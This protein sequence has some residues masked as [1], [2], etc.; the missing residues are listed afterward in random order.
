MYFDQ[1]GYLGAVLLYVAL[2][3]E[4]YKM[5][6]TLTVSGLYSYLYKWVVKQNKFTWME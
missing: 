5:A 6:V 2:R 3:I 1:I 4:I